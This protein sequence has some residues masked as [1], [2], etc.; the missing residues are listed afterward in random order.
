MLNFQYCSF[1]HKV[2]F[3]IIIFASIFSCWR[4]ELK[5]REERLKRLRRSKKLKELNKRKVAVN[6]DTML[7]RFDHARLNKMKQQE[8]EDKMLIN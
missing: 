6:F 7:G 3:I 5:R 8:A 2:A 4:I 1:R